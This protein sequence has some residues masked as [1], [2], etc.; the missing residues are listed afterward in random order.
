MRIPFQNRRRTAIGYASLLALG[1]L[2]APAL[3][4]TSS[5]PS[6]PVA[7]QVN[8]PWVGTNRQSYKFSMVVDGA[9]FA[10]PIH[11]YI[12]VVPSPIRGALHNAIDNLN[13]PRTAGNDILQGH[14]IKAGTATARFVL[15]STFGIAGLIDVAGQS[16]IAWHE[17][18]FGET[19]GR[20]GVAPGPYIFVPF[21]G[22]SSVRDGIG[23]LI[24]IFGDPV[25]IAA[26]GLNT[27]FGQVRTGVGI[28]DA[29]AQI[30]GQLQALN[31]DFTDPYATVRSAY[32]QQRA[33]LINAARG[34]TPANDVQALPDFGAEPPPTSPPSS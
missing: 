27:T 28:V 5:A 11:A 10:P 7:A 13:E 31:Q 4:Q 3:A 34:A 19:L 12:R 18:D 20:Y 17:S 25:A 14:L 33:A 6:V 29:R 15:N 22:P 24:D 1:L 30:D 2:A 32:A 26:G 8:D 23:R 9:I 16:G 21:D